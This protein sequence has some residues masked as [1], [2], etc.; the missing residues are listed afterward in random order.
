L[1]VRWSGRGSLYYICAYPA[2]VFMACWYAGRPVGEL[3]GRLNF[4]SA[5]AL[6]SISGRDLRPPARC[7]LR[8]M[9]AKQKPRA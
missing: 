6:I 7:A 9:G 2:T 5:L 3:F 4:S 1:Y 8:A